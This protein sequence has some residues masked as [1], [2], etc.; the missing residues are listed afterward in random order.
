[1]RILYLCHRIP[2]PPDK[3]DKIRA[4]H[5]LKAIAARH[6]V[7]LFTLADDARDLAH[8]DALLGFCRRVTVAQ[9]RPKLARLQS[10]P[11]LFT[12]KPLTIPYFS[13]PELHAQVRAALARERYDRIFV[14]CSAMA[15][16]VPVGGPPMVVDLVDVDSDKWTQYATHTRFPFSF[17][18]RREGRTLE[19][20]ERSICE[21]AERVLVSTEREARLA[22]RIAPSACVDVLANG[23]DTGY[24]VPAAEKPAE[25]AVIFTGDMSY[26]PNEQAVIFFAREVLPAI[27]HLGSGAGLWPAPGSAP[28]GQRPCPLRFL[29]VGRNPGP[30]VLAL[31]EIEGVEVT[32]FVP[33]VRTWIGRARVAVAPF[34]I[35]AG[36]QNKILEAMASGLP[37]VST[38]RAAQG[39]SPRVA[40][41][42]QTADT[43]EAIADK[44]V[45]LL[46]DP[47]AATRRGLDGRRRVAEDYSWESALD[48]LLRLVEGSLPLAQ[49]SPA[50]PHTEGRAASGR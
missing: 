4:F 8:R 42:V 16:Y 34:T 7:D 12:S 33:D 43:A 15:Q 2:Y 47:D 26:F 39:L 49:A 31:K 1:M 11:Y 22:R 27:R 20:Y 29:I 30:K 50:A 9:V 36:I 18:Y 21:R 13:S 45:V 14:Y 5:Q 40:E 46:R 28:A 25:P 3:G 41:L 6:E 32:G 23:V 10:L 48:R 24:F 38:S 17:V 37:V 35:A 44:V 19:A